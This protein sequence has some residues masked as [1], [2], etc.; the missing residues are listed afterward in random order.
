MWTLLAVGAVA[1]I[2]FG[3]A[4]VVLNLWADLRRR[5]KATKENGSVIWKMER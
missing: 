4:A 1:S 2:A 3:L 5:T